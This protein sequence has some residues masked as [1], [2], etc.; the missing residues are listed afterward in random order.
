MDKRT[1]SIVDMGPVFHISFSLSL[2]GANPFIFKVLG[3][4][5][6]KCDGISEGRDPPDKSGLFIPRMAKA[7][8]DFYCSRLF[9]YLCFFLAS[10]SRT[11]PQWL[12]RK[13]NRGEKPHPGELRSSDNGTCSLGLHCDVQ[14]KHILRVERGRKGMVV[15]GWPDLQCVLLTSILWPVN[16]RTLWESIIRSPY[17]PFH[18]PYHIILLVSG[19]VAD[20]SGLQWSIHVG[21]LP[22][23]D[24]CNTTDIPICYWIP[25]TYFPAIRIPPPSLTCCCPMVSC[26]DASIQLCPPWH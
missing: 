7:F 25:P 12:T 6:L 3:L 10:R 15:I 16:R 1:L 18:C 2:S 5:R 21:I 13:C 19:C 22:Q 20:V 14:L 8:L 9:P 11:K 24:C 23:P 26:G 17:S 4:P